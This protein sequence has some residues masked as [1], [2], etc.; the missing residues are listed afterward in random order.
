MME[1]VFQ[2]GQHHLS[3]KKTPSGESF[4]CR[5]FNKTGPTQKS[6]PAEAM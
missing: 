4:F 5:C 1:S 6:A 2:V 3:V